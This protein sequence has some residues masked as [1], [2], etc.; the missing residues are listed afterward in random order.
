MSGR[1]VDQQC[2]IKVS[3]CYLYPVYIADDSSNSERVACAA[4]MEVGAEDLASRDG[5][6]LFVSAASRSLRQ[7]TDRDV[8][9]IS[10]P[11]H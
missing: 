5:T 3:V 4:A 2:Y 7:L 8:V 6:I 10:S 9:G 11:S 1:V